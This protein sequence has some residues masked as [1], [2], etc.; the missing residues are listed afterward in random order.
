LDIF[1]EVQQPPALVPL[2]SRY[3]RKKLAQGR[4]RSRSSGTAV[5]P[6]AALG[7]GFN[8]LAPLPSNR[9]PLGDSGGKDGRGGTS[10]AG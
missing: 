6:R 3:G 7:L 4:A 5:P 1:R 9:Q 8:P 10:V 2:R